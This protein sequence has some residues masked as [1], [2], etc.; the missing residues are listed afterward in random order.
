MALVE[1][2]VAAMG[3]CGKKRDTVAVCSHGAAVSAG[4]AAATRPRPGW[5]SRGP[6]ATLV[7]EL[8]DA[9]RP[10]QQSERRRRAVF[11]HVAQLVNGCFAGE[12]VLVRHP[13]PTEGEKEEKI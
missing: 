3:V 4:E 8:I 11:Q 12:N 13:L 1:S 6:V 7:N 5:G 2:S 10:T 9:L